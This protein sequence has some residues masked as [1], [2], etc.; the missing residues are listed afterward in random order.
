MGGKAESAE[1]AIQLALDTDPQDPELHRELG[2]VYHA[3]QRDK[4]AVRAFRFYLDRNPA[5][6]DGET[7]KTM[8]KNLEIEE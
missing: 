5:A 8:I 4:E 1:G 2:Y 3:M 6:T 7:I